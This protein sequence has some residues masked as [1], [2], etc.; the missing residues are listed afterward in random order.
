MCFRRIVLIGLSVILCWACSQYRKVELVRSGEVRMLLTLPEDE[1]ECEDED[2]DIE[3]DVESEVSGEPFLM[4]AV[5]DEETGEMVATD[6]LTAS[7]VTAKFRNVAERAGYVTIG[8][9]I[10][11]PAQ[12]A[13]SR[14]RL[15]LYPQMI[16]QDDTVALE[17]VIVTGARYREEQLRGYQRYRKF[18]ASIV[19]DTT[20]FIRIGQLE[21]FLQRHFPDTYKMKND[22][23]YVSDPQAQTLFGATQEEAFRHYT[24]RMLLHINEK[25]LSRKGEMFQRYVKD[26]IE[27]EGVRL[28]TVFCAENGDFVYGYQH[29]FKTRPL[30]KK[31][32][33]SL[34][35]ALFAD[36]VRIADLPKPED[37]TFYISTL[38]SLLDDSPKFKTIVIERLAYENTKAYL[39]FKVGSSEVDLSLGDNQSELQ[40]VNEYISHVVDQTDYA[41]DSLVIVASCSPEGSW[42]YNGILS[43]NRSKAILAQ[44]KKEVPEEMQS[45][46]KSSQIPE[47]WPLL[48]SLLQRDTVIDIPVRNRVLEMID[49]MSDP[50]VTEKQLSRLPAYSYIKE[51]LYP[52]LR[53]VSFDFH[54]HKV[55]MVKDTV[56]TTEL[57][58]IYMSGLEA[59]RNLDYVTALRIL[60]PYGDYNAALA[61]LSSDLNHS[62]VEILRDM[63]VADPKVCYLMAV[64]MVRLD[65]QEEA[66]GYYQKAVAQDPSLRHRANLDPE[67]SSILLLTN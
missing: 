58:T 14:F 57:D 66:K 34:R 42:R 7:S 18:L 39:D 51:S 65:E 35:G 29:T 25:R 17:T 2:R 4:H 10:N 32:V 20:D 36:G 63:D 3:V 13:D 15:K 64:A 48:K 59:L 40:R 19:T 50:D 38:S 47:N 9:E 28:D 31:V 1:V 37:L 62:A 12:M 21:L 11:V 52:R 53:S 33:V 61:C 49:R 54:L 30:L 56:H 8:F 55:G 46:L 26:P 41:L 45:R 24:K 16:M 60:R 43:G 22:S 44:I 6:I 67:L 5:K 23:S 27:K